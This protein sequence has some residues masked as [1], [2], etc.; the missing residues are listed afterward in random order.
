[1][2]PPPS[3]PSDCRCHPSTRPRMPRPAAA[4]LTPPHLTSRPRMHRTPTSHLAP[5]RPTAMRAASVGSTPAGPHPRRPTAMREA[6]A[7]L[8]HQSSLYPLSTSGAD[9]ALVNRRGLRHGGHCYHQRRGWRGSWSGRFLAVLQDPDLL[10]DK[11]PPPPSS[12][13][14]PCHQRANGCRGS[15]GA[16]PSA[17]DTAGGR[18]HLLRR[19]HGGRLRPDPT[20]PAL[21]RALA[22]GWWSRFRRRHQRSSLSLP[23]QRPRCSP[24]CSPTPPVSCPFAFILVA[25]P[26]LKAG[27][28]KCSSVGKIDGYDL[29]AFSFFFLSGF[30][31]VRLSC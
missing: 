10:H 16:S 24:L 15:R 11:P 22:P 19:H 18:H 29:M 14:A 27:G 3:P 21:P 12:L 23:I 20:P 13:S 7:R 6:R 4:C 26:A 25:V 9:G 31:C 8:R 28:S 30:G 2:P 17:G 5:E 1:M